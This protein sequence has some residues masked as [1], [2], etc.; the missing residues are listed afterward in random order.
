MTSAIRCCPKCHFENLLDTEHCEFCGW[1]LLNSAGNETLFV[2][3]SLHEAV[4]ENAV[5][6]LEACSAD[7]PVSPPINRTGTFNLAG[8]L[9]H[10]EV[11]QIIGKGG[12]GTVYRATDQTLQRDVAIK[13]LRQNKALGQAQKDMLLEEA[14]TICKLNHPNI[15]TVFDV[16]RGSGNSFIIMEWI[17]GETLDKIIPDKGL[18][19]KT[20]VHYASEIILGLSHAHQ[21]QIIHRDIKPQNIILTN[22]GKVKILD[23]GIAALAGQQANLETT[24]TVLKWQNRSFNGTPGYVSPEQALGKKRLD[25][26]SDIFSF[27]VLFYQML[28]GKPPFS[29][30]NTNEKMTSLI[31]GDYKPLPAHIPEDI[32]AIINYCLKN[33]TSERYQTS[34]ALF[35]D[36]HRYQSGNPVSVIKGKRYWLQKK[37]LL[38]KWP[39][40]LL[41]LV[42]LGAVGQLTWQQIQATAQAQ[43]ESLLTEF[44]SQ[45]ENLEADVQ[46]T[47]MSPPHD[48][49]ARH[50]SWEHS[51]TEIARQIRQLGSI[52]EGPGHYAMGRM[53]YVLQD[54]SNALRNLQIAWDV[55]FQQD[56]VAYY[57]ALTHSALYQQQYANIQNLSSKSAKRDRLAKLDTQHKEPAVSY[58]QQGMAGS[59]FKGYALALLAFYQGDIDRALEEL[60]R[61][62][63]TPVWFYEHH[64]LRGDI[65]LREADK[66]GSQGKQDAS[67]EYVIEA[68]QSYQQASELGRSDLNVYVK[69]LSGYHRLINNALYGDGKNLSELFAQALPN[70]QRAEDIAPLNYQVLFQKG[71]LSAQQSNYEQW[72]GGDPLPTQNKTI[73]ALEEALALAP[74]NPDVL[75]NLGF[76]WFKKIELL[77]DR[78]L[79]VEGLFAKGS[80]IFQRIDEE[81][82]DYFYYNRFGNFLR[83]K[84]KNEA[85]IAQIQSFTDVD[86]A[87][88][89][90]HLDTF[91][92]AEYA[93]KQASRLQP[94]RFGAIINLASNYLEWKN[95]L[96]AKE[97]KATIERAI[98]ALDKVI[99]QDPDMFVANYYQGLA[100][101]N[102]SQVQSYLFED[103]SGSFAQA[104]KYF[105]QA[106]NA[107]PNHPYV[108]NEMVLW[109]ID[110]AE[111]RWLA[112]ENPEALFSEAINQLAAGLHA[113]PDSVFLQRNLQYLKLLLFQI[114]HFDPH[115]VLPVIEDL[116]SQYQHS[117]E[118]N[119]YYYLPLLLQNKVHNIE[120][121]HLIQAQN[122]D[123]SRLMLAQFNSVTGDHAEAEKLLNKIPYN[124]LGIG[125]LRLYQRQNYQKWLASISVSG[126]QT[127]R[128]QLSYVTDKLR[129]VEQDLKFHYPALWRKI[130]LAQ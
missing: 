44:T 57:L 7:T 61:L 40:L 97:A 17:E 14:R 69:T 111:Y 68:L 128:S 107:Q 118:Y 105:S 129:D 114:Q 49:T 109:F 98:N 51:I 115:F 122:P 99:S 56:R 124:H 78:D 43:R 26:R 22:D 103:N 71:L 35:D 58:L 108:R 113:H 19:L 28:T 30:G 106:E 29:G 130:N 65:L 33:A 81:Q 41:T 18:N 91:Q 75:L 90:A 127:A 42:V 80:D 92:K 76:A 8:N 50:K 34:A 123:D 110:N 11:Q 95:Y 83:E 46:L 21:S 48:T 13:V 104:K 10:F 6:Q 84:A 89:N 32:R 73:A 59:P 102:L 119:I 47:R 82:R 45:V 16:A 20:A 60:S 1:Q 5:T 96:T 53:Y 94:L 4:D 93:F 125:L 2:D 117:E 37:S 12:M 87:A 72:F 64:I 63:A 9:A 15:V 62:T 74:E 101:R 31:T 116:A 52:A 126:D 77:Q 121:N 3:A 27:G 67:G 88:N 23:F 112:G 25:G 39:L 55:G 85:G 120:K 38:Y 100:Y 36:L 24:E 86:Y 70:L 66:L 79:P 54:Y